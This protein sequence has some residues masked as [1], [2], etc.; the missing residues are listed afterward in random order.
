MRIRPSA[1]EWMVIS[2]G[3]V[4][5]LIQARTVA[6]VLGKIFLGERRQ[7][8]GEVA[9][10]RDDDGGGEE[11]GNGDNNVL[12]DE[13]VG[14]VDFFTLGVASSSL[15]ILSQ[16]ANGSYVSKSGSTGSWK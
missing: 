8:V 5:S 16:V 1:R 15:R 10:G 13:A 14:A 2:T 3:A 12:E 11:G 6:I 9:T 4:P 7:R